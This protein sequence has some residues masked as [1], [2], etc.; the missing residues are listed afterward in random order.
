MMQ[1]NST[2]TL[3]AMGGS[4]AELYPDFP[5]AVVANAS[6]DVV[7]ILVLP[8]SYASHPD[9]IT[10]TERA[11]NLGMARERCLQIEQAC[12]RVSPRMCVAKLI[13]VFTRAEACDSANLE[14]FADEDVAAIFILGGDQTIAMQVL[15]GTPLETKLSE[16]FARGVIVAGTSAGAAVMATTMLGGF[17]PNYDVSTS[18]YRGAV[19]MW[20]TPQKRGLPFGVRDAIIDQHFYQRGRMGRLLNAIALPDVPHMGVGIDAYTGVRISNGARLD[21]VFGLYTVTI[22]D[23][24]TNR[25]ADSVT[26]RGANK[27]LSLRNI[28]VHLLAPGDF[29]YDLTTRQ[30]SLAAPTPQLVRGF[31]AL[32]LPG[33]AGALLMAG[34]LTGESTSIIARFKQHVGGEHARIAFVVLDDEAKLA[35][36]KFVLALGVSC[37]IIFCDAKR[38]PQI[39]SQVTGIILLASDQSK[40]DVDA[41]DAIKSAWLGGVPLLTDD[42][43][44]AVVGAFYS[45][46][47]PTAQSEDAT[48]KSFLRGRTCIVPGW[49][50][51]NAMFE[52]QAL[53]DN[54]WGRVFSLAS[55][56]PDLVVFAIAQNTALEITRDGA[57]VVGENVVVA[58][59]L[60]QATLAHG[61][62]DAFVVANGLLDV[63][64][65]GDWVEPN[66][67]SKIRVRAS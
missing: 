35:A 55:S 64:A 51:V 37:K 43:G 56:R 17:A 5:H 65:P 12:Q 63:F 3:L 21:R 45:A 58:L 4:Y 20:H 25:S 54:R 49:G 6:G 13:P 41:L 28:L 1:K 10:A 62:N 34:Q 31:D 46:H 7:K 2:S 38:A 36:E 9:E 52:P 15:A 59:D 30:H 53:H 24:E 48:Q 32:T 57:N 67:S 29:A 61:T 8:I 11:K 42:A 23:A 40:L 60:R 27:T 44:A 14:N 47:T 66:C 26:Y 39:P 22:L 33:G 16:A 19:E 50:L 18:L